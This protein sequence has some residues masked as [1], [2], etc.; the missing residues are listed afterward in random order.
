MATGA[1][2]RAPDAAS[3]HKDP[4]PA[5]KGGHVLAYFFYIA[6]LLVAGDE[7]KWSTPLAQ[8]HLAL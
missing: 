3:G 6:Y 2:S 7:G 5:V 4:L 8:A 1:G